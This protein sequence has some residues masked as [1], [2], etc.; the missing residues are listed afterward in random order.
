VT[1]IKTN[2]KALLTV[3]LVISLQ[4]QCSVVCLSQRHSHTQ[5][6]D[7]S[8]SDHNACEHSQPAQGSESGQRSP[9]GNP[10]ETCFADSSCDLSASGQSIKVIP[11]IDHAGHLTESNLFGSM[12]AVVVH[13]SEDFSPPPL[14]TDT[15]IFSLRI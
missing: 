9:I 11:L 3:M 2:I 1:N 15:R 8:N 12:S 5:Q 14:N 10:S 6:S 4:V 13:G 7:G